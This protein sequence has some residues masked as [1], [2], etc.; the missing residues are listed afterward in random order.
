MQMETLHKRFHVITID[1]FV[2]RMERRVPFENSSCLVTFDDGWRDNYTHALPILKQYEIPAVVFLP[3]DFIGG[4]RLFW[5][6]QLTH[7]I[8]Q[9]IKEIK[10]D[11]TRRDQLARLLAPLGLES[12]LDTSSHDPCL[13]MVMDAVRRNKTFDSVVMKNTLEKLAEELNVSLERFQETD[14]FL[15]WEQVSSMAKQ[16]IT[17]GG[18]GAEHRILTNISLSEAEQ[19]IRASKEILDSRLHLKLVVFSYPNG[20]WSPEVARLVEKSGFRAAFTTEPGHVRCDDERFSIRRLNIHEGLVN[21]EPLF[22]A[23][24]VGLF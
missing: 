5:Q 1:Q 6:E 19:E 22:L 24:I 9:A 17:F 11:L 14:S 12:V 21:S 16:G 2:E 4:T 13:I 15:S 8:L 23:R 10:R 20:N 7:L 18:H 3:V